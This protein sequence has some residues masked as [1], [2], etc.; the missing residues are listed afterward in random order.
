MSG[1]RTEENL[2]GV[3][4]VGGIFVG[5]GVSIEKDARNGQRR[6]GIN[7]NKGAIQG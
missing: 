5:V 6:G 4:G 2:V 1:M 3:L 7:N